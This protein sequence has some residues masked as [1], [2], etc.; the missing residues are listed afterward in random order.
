MADSVERRSSDAILAIARRVILL[1]LLLAMGGISVELL[2]LE[3]VGDV[4]QLIPLCLLVIG[5]AVVAWHARAP[6]SSSAR[7]LRALMML[8]VLSGLLGVFLH[9]RGNVEFELEQ[10]PRAT[11]WAL[12]REAMMGATPALAPGVMV[13]IGLLGLLYAFMSANPKTSDVRRQKSEVRDSRSD[14]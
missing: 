4:W 13:Q 6:S 12:F 11:R 1:I 5:I 14:S 7:T 8:F 3:H 2:L 10:N 9:Y